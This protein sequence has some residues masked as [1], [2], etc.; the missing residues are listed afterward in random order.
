MRDPDGQFQGYF[1][2]LLQRVGMGKAPDDDMKE[3]TINVF[4]PP[5][6]LGDNGSSLNTL[7]K[8]LGCNHE[9]GVSRGQYSGSLSILP[10]A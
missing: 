1:T 10:C 7:E 2:M 6:F 8:F 3:H 5:T 4:A 9:M